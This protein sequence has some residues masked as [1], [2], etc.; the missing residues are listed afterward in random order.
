MKLNKIT[1]YGFFLAVLAFIPAR[2]RAQQFSGSILAGVNASQIDGDQL[3]GFDKIGLTGGI[4][5]T[6]ETESIIDYHVEFLY[7]Q[8][9]SRRDIFNPE[10]DP[11]IEISLRYIELPV[12]VSISDWWQP[13][14]EYHKISAHA[15]VSYGR[16]ISSKAIDNANPDDQSFARL[17]E[18]FNQNDLSWFA[19]ATIRFTPNWGATF[20]YTRGITPLL[21]PEKHDLDMKRLLNYLITIRL[22]YTFN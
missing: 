12:Y 14:L 3:A 11:D 1:I 6:I 13:E 18:F 2:M 19:G 22:E 5:A 8:R 17:T 10:Y 21:N 7:S 16:L 15:G 20:R 4:K 9:G